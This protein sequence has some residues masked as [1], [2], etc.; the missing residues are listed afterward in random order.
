MATKDL[1]R[2]SVHLRVDP[3]HQRTKVDLDLVHEECLGG[4]VANR[5]D[6]VRKWSWPWLTIIVRCRQCAR[7]ERFRSGQER[8]AIEEA[9]LQV[10]RGLREKK[11]GNVLLLST[12]LELVCLPGRPMDGIFVPKIRTLPDEVELADIHAR[13]LHLAWS[14]GTPRLKA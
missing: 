5:V 3:Y 11:V 7:E 13:R 6:F 1:M 2:I 10:L 4:Q 9:L 8:W 12:K 14:N